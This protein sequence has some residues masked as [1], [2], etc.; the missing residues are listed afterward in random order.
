MTRTRTHNCMIEANTCILISTHHFEHCTI[1][2]V[3]SIN[4][5]L[6]IAHELTEFLQFAVKAADLFLEEYLSLRQQRI[7]LLQF[8]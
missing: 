6:W 4:N 3:Y 2:I 5:A 7:L 8:L 1:Y